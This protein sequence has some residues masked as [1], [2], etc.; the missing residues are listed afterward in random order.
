MSSPTRQSK[1]KT[2]SVIT[3]VEK[4]P[5][6]TSITTRVETP[7]RLSMVLVVTEVMAPRLLALK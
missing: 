5:S 6:V 4:S 3:A 1:R 2:A 7:E